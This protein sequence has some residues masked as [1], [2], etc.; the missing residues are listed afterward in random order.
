MLSLVVFLAFVW[1]IL[2]ALFLQ[3]TRTGHYLAVR[4]TWIAVIV[5][6]GVDLLLALLVIPKDAW[7]YIVAIIVASSVGIIMRSVYN[8]RQDEKALEALNDE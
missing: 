4:R 8:E 6:L 3:C 5:G 7:S 2:W 1:G